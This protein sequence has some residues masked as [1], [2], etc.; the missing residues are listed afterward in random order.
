MSDSLRSKA[1][2]VLRQSSARREASSPVG[3]VGPVFGPLPSVL[4][5][6]N[7][8][9]VKVRQLRFKI[10]AATER[11][12][13]TDRTKMRDLLAGRPVMDNLTEE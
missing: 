8:P 5:N 12:F 4:G 13:W 9:E 1:A 6:A 3:F 7:Q 11:Q 10:D 2:A